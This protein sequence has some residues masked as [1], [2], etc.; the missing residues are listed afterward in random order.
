MLH[1]CA[2]QC[3]LAASRHTR[4]HIRKSC[5]LLLTSGLNRPQH[6]TFAP[7][8]ARQAS[9]RNTIQQRALCLAQKSACVA[10]CACAPRPACWQWMTRLPSL[11]SAPLAAATATTPGGPA[12][13][14]IPILVSVCSA[15]PS[16]LPR[17]LPSPMPS[18][19]CVLCDAT[20]GAGV[21]QAA[22]R[23]AGEGSF[24]RKL[25]ASR[26]HPCAWMAEALA[27]P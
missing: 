14:W 7:S 12:R 26:G 25:A 6:K 5:K 20:S 24:V 16:L 19:A 11:H 9:A 17:P 2:N 23:T 18:G 1:L 13:H 22:C 27:P 15:M 21:P 8:Q 4:L 3:F 10:P